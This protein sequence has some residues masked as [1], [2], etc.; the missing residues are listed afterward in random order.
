MRPDGLEDASQLRL[1]IDREGP[2][3]GR[4]HR[5]AQRGAG[6]LAGLSYVGDFP[7]AGRMQRVVVQAETEPACGPRPAATA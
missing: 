3:P 1:D 4:V 6:H 5:R 2:G 7:N